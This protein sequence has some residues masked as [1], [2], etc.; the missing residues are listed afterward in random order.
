M[1]GREPLLKHNRSVLVDALILVGVLTILGALA[2]PAF[3]H[4]V[5]PT[6]REV[7]APLTPAPPAPAGL[8]PSTANPRT[9]Q[10]RR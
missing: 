8:A 3:I 4:Y 5:Q 9:Q 10:E 1:T 2:V 6:P 7:S